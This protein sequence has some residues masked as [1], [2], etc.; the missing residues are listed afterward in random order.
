VKRR[1]R[2]DGEHL[3]DLFRTHHNVKAGIRY[4]T[5]REQYGCLKVKLSVV[6]GVIVN[7]IVIFLPSQNMADSQL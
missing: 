6:Q 4:P 1:R 5:F 7:M 2:L 3:V